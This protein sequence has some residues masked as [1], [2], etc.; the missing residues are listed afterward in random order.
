MNAAAKNRR[1]PRWKASLGLIVVFGSAC[2]VAVAD[3][4]VRGPRPHSPH[5]PHLLYRMSDRSPTTR[6][7]T[8]L[9][10]Q[11]E[12]AAS[13]RETPEVRLYVGGM[14]SFRKVNGMG[15]VNRLALV[16]LAAS[17]SIN[18]VLH[19]S[20]QLLLDIDGEFYRTYPTSDPRLYT[21]GPTDLGYTET[22]IV[23]IDRHLLTLLASA[24]SVRGRVGLW[25]AFDL[26]PEVIARLGDLL[27]A[28]PDDFPS[29]H[30]AV[31]RLPLLRVTY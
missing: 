20:R 4:D 29:G 27:N 21:F 10:Q 7:V 19:E 26:P 23:P 5:S 3:A 11:L 28:L 25:L 30:R 14:A 18:P 9:P 1:R 13:F 8:L 16:I 2:S 15:P 17:D 6:S 22:V 24:K 31:A 12:A